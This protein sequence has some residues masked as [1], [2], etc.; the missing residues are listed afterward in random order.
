MDRRQ[1]IKNLTALSALSL[2]PDVNL[3]VS[4]RLK[5]LHIIGLGTAGT[6]IAV[7]LK[8]N[9]IVGKYTCITRFPSFIEPKEVANY[10]KGFFHIEY[11][12]RLEVS[13]NYDSIDENQLKPLSID[14]QER[15]SDNCFYIIL[16]GLGSWTGTSLIQRTLEFLTS[17]NEQYLAICQL[18]FE[19]DGEFRKNFALVKIGRAHV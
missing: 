8:Q 7:R 14:M 10:I 15:L 18:P 17:N 13:L 9:G 11:D 1:L 12:Y 3:L 4:S 6:N 16:V 19:F 2:I 5:K